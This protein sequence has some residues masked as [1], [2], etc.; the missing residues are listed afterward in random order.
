MIFDLEPKWVRRLG[1]PGSHQPAT[2]GVD[3]NVRDE[4]AR[5]QLNSL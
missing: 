4:F 3:D 2:L 5:R 1:I